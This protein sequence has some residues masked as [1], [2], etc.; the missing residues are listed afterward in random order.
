VQLGEGLTDH[1]RVLTQ[2]Q[3]VHLPFTSFE[4]EVELAQNKMCQLQFFWRELSSDSK[5][6]VGYDQ[7]GQDFLNGGQAFFHEEHGVILQ[8][9]H[10]AFFR[11][12][13]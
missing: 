13:T 10:S 9:D 1:K 7:I 6:S 5:G 3:S 4:L 12:L 8:I 2:V 11:D